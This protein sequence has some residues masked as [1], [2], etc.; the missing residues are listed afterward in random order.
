MFDLF[1]SV[2]CLNGRLPNQTWFIEHKNL[3]IIAADGA[4]NDLINKNIMPDL[5]IGDLDSIEP[6]YLNNKNI[7]RITDQNTTDFEKC[8]TEIKHRSLFPSLILGINGGEI[9]HTIYNLNC[10]MRYAKELSLIFLDL[11]E[12][13]NFKW[14][15]PLF[16]KQ[17]FVGK[18]GKII[19][20]LP[21]AESMISTKGLKWDLINTNL[22]INANASVR[23]KVEQRIITIDVHS[24]NLL[25]ILEE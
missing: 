14:G 11:D 20:L 5:I 4:C 2:L 15:I 9:D 8:L 7:I 25:M 16:N 10:F 23:N 24:G 1:K 22:S 19:S 18:Q 17:T 13:N 12:Y 21:W 6:E 3:T